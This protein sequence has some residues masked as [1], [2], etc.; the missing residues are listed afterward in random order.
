MSEPEKK[1]KGLVRGV[2][3]VFSDK[4]KEL[5][6]VHAAVVFVVL[7]VIFTFGMV[8]FTSAVASGVV[9]IIQIIPQVVGAV[10]I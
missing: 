3:E 1:E 6:P 4:M 8:G 7:A 2:V 10:T 9:K 5:E